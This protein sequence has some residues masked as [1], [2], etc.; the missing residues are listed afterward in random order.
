M[1]QQTFVEKAAKQMSEQMD[2]AMGFAQLC[3]GQSEKFASLWM[4]QSVEA[5][6]ETQ[7]FLK[8]WAATGTEMTNDLSRAFMA[9]MKDAAKMFSPEAPKAGKA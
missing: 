4:T 5:S 2:R 7:K 6:K 8:D 1:T 9:S 3:Q